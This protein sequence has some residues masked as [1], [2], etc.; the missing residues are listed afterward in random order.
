VPIVNAE[1]E[2][3]LAARMEH[4]E[5]AVPNDT[6]H[7]PATCSRGACPSR[8]TTGPGTWIPG[9]APAA[10][11]RP[12]G[13]RRRRPRGGSGPTGSS[14]TATPGH[15]RANAST[16]SFVCGR[17]PSGAGAAFDRTGTARSPGRP[18]PPS[19]ARSPGSTRDQGPG[20]PG[21]VGHVPVR[22][23]RTEISLGANHPVRTAGS[24]DPTGTMSGPP[25][26]GP[27]APFSRS[28]RAAGDGDR[29][30]RGP[31]DH[32][33]TDPEPGNRDYRDPVR[34]CTRYSSSE[35]RL[36]EPFAHQAGARSPRVPTMGGPP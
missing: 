27:A 21:V 25:G 13:H 14:R 20:R 24:A 22:R 6:M 15:T 16:T 33:V 12:A 11:P 17:G 8:R 2:A 5:H 18:A 19:S 28:G 30:A 32:G 26:E 34:R 35:N 36:I 10:P 29:P 23:D 1:N 7:M 3:E 31:V 9:E 4:A